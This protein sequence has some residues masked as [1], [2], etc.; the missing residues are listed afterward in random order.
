[1]LG[2][3]QDRPLLISSL[4]EHA[5]TY[6]PTR[7]IVARTVEGPIHRTNYAEIHRRAKRVANALAS[8][9]VGVADR[10]GTLAWNTHRHFELYFGVSG[11]GAILHTV[12]PRLFPEQIEYIVNHAEDKVLFFDIGFAPLVEKLA[13]ALKSVQHYV[14][15]TD[16][17]N[18]PAID[19]PNLL[20]YEDL[21]AEHSDTYDWPELDERAASSLC[22]TSGTTGNPKGVLYSHRSTVLHSLV[23]CA[24]DAFAVGA[25]T[26]VLLAVPMFHANAWGMPYAAAMAGA[27]M[28]MPGP[29]LNGQSL[30]E[31]MRDEG[32][33]VSQAVPTIWLMLFQFLDE[34]PEIDMKG[35]GLKIIGSGGAASPRSMIERCERDFGVEYL[36]AWGM[37][38][39]SPIGTTGRLLPKHAALPKDEQTTIKMKAGR[40]VWGVGLKII[41]DDGQELPHDGRAFGHLHVR[42][43]WIASGYF[44]HT[45]GEV[46]DKDGWFPTGDIG[47]IDPDG[48]VQLVDRAK[49]VIKSGGEWISSIDL[50]NT[51][52]GHPA[53]HEAAIIAV[54]H[55]KW[56]ERPL[57]LAV[58]RPGKDVTR[59]ELLQYL[60]ERVVKWWVPDD[61]VFVDQLPH[62]AT[63]KLLKTKLREDYRNYRLPTA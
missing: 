7:E 60:S 56:Q 14:A 1:M 54:A 59:E 3:M 47:T 23:A 30:Y 35:L 57:L 49:D 9:G 29:H 24:A 4:I 18:M 22:Y 15:M 13:P 50:E 25:S 61:V 46:L 43:P 55:P 58:K 31:L 40:A 2:L 48:Y 16:R 27:K 32:V 51:A 41:G 38:E 8:L 34:H 20:C 21:L 53:V 19:V 11:S 5:A 44:K 45:G 17:A 36:Q 39:T 26:S 52:I 12:N 6:H 62:T 63:G 10:V 37:T 33:T 42:G 28:V